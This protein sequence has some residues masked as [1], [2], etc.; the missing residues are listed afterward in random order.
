MSCSSYD[1]GWL[2]AANPKFTTLRSHQTTAVDEI[3]SHF[4]HTNIVVVEAPTGSGKTVLAEVVRKEL[5]ER[6]LFLCSTIQLQAQFAA[7]FPYSAVLKGRR[8]YPTELADVR[9]G[10]T[11]E[12]CTGTPPTKA[13]CMWC[14]VRGTCPYEI[15]KAA[16]YRAQ[17]GVLNTSYFLHEANGVAKGIGR[18]RAFVVVD[19]ADLLERELLS[20]VEF[21]ITPGIVKDFRNTPPPKGSHKKTI[22]EY[23]GELHEQVGYWLSTHEEPLG[24]DDITAVR[25]YK[26]NDRLDGQ[27][28]R[29]LASDLDENWVRDNDAGPLVLK[30]VHVKDWAGDMLWRHSRRVIA[31]EEDNPWDEP[32]E[33]PGKW[34]LMSGTIIAPELYMK[35]L[36]KQPGEYEF[37]QVESTFPVENRPIYATNSADMSM[38]GGQD[39]GGW[40]RALTAL[41]HIVESHPDERV[42]VHCVSYKLAKYLSLSVPQD[43]L[44]TYEDSASK[45]AALERYTNIENGVLVA[46]S[47]DRGVDFAGDM[48]TVCVVAKLPFPYLGDPQTSARMHSR[49]EGLGQ[50]W[51]ELETGRSLVQMTG[52]GVRSETDTCVTYILD[53]AFGGFIRKTYTTPKWWREAVSREFN[54]K[55]WRRE[56]GL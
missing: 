45:S 47:M 23:L 17:V 8:N 56:A 31:G 2:T 25:K 28:A 27:L 38:K 48:C 42:L 4:E 16:T 15:A 13:D 49:E 39:E 30:P 26:R 41:G 19:E 52:R 51:Y 53:M 5:H 33:E 24:T 1:L 43:R 6:G 12:D 50:T 18:S 36:G 37:V 14:E 34:L 55:R 7:D 21:S 20:Y 9:S 54:G 44:V 22:V 3:L 35:A 40:K 46:S 29:I 10:I 11:C 32:E